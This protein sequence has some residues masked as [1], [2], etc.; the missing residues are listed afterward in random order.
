MDKVKIL[1]FVGV[2]IS[3]LHLSAQRYYFEPEYTLG[4]RGGATASFVSFQ[5]SVSHTMLYG[6]QA[7][8]AFR[9]ISDRH[10]G[11]QVETNFT[12]RGWKEKSDAY[13]YERQLN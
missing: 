3:S 1:L 8:I 9:Y 2:I 6:A 5:P 7:G 11:I 12:Q 13:A 10:F 4:A